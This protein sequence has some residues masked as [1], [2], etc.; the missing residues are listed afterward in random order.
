MSRKKLCT[1]TLECPCDFPLINLYNA[2][3]PLRFTDL[4]AA[5][6]FTWWSIC[7]RKRWRKTGSAAC[8]TTAITAE[9]SPKPINSSYVTV[10]VYSRLIHTERKNTNSKTET[11]LNFVV[12]TVRASLH[13]ASASTLQQFCDDANNTC[14]IESNA[15]APKWVSTPFWSITSVITELSQR[16]YWHMVQTGPWKLI[17]LASF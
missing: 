3:V 10:Y 11:T 14:L 16:W 6:E 5:V 8:W 12:E 7:T 1:R 2:C 9:T 15:V 13:R 4:H 17:I